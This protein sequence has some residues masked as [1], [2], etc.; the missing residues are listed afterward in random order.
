MRG[1]TT[2]SIWM[3][4][5]LFAG[6]CMF[7]I[8][9]AKIPLGLPADAAL[10]P[11]L[12]F[13]LVV[14]WVIRSPRTATLPLIAAMALLA[15]V[16]LMRPVGLAAILVVLTSEYFRA[17]RFSIREQM[18]VVEWLFFVILY[19]GQ[20]GLYIFVL[21]ISFSEAPPLGLAMKFI[22]ITALAYP[23]VVALIH[24]VFRVRSPKA[25]SGAEIG[26]RTG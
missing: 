7:C 4:R 16:L 26:G 17:Q 9:A 14:A 20:M 6:L 21:A 5:A 2:T 22:G 10:M 24:T 18:F 1:D 19:A 3:G 25:E 12:F 15:D 13:V 23:I 8:I 11:D